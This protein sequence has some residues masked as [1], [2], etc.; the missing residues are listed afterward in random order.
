MDVSKGSVLSLFASS[1]V[2]C[3]VWRVGV[4]DGFVVDVG[5]VELLVGA[6]VMLDALLLSPPEESPVV[7]D[8]GC[9]V[10][11]DIVVEVSR[12]SREE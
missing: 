12:G 4:C 11:W 8:R 5:L 9:R 10:G 3:G 1:P 7:V 2:S 6:L